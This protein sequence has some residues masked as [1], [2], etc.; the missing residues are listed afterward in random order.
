MVAD[1]QAYRGCCDATPLYRE[2]IDSLRQSLELADLQ[3]GNRGDGT[4]D[5]WGE[6]WVLR[7]RRCVRLSVCLIMCVC[8]VVC[9]GGKKYPRR[10]FFALAASMCSEVLR[11]SVEHVL[12]P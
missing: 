3:G 8:P 1:Y 10:I 6:G 7:L 2:S 4:C 9:V 12:L 5:V 11:S